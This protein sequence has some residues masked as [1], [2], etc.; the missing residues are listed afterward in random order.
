MHYHLKRRA[1]FRVAEYDSAKFPPVYRTVGRDN[2][3]P[4]AFG[5]PLHRRPA[6][7]LQIVGNVIRIEDSATHFREE[8]GQRALPAGDTAR[9]GKKTG[10]HGSD[11]R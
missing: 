8:P 2:V 9:D 11:G 7:S 6:G 10:F 3:A 4:E 1:R 5:N